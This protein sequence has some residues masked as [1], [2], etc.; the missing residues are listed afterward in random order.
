[1]A[2]LPEL[3]PDPAV[4][5]QHGGDVGEPAELAR[6]P[7]HPQDL[8]VAD[9]PEE[10][11]DHEEDR[12]AVHPGGD[13]D[14]AERGGPPPR[15][16]VRGGGGAVPVGLVRGLGEGAGEHEAGE[17]AE[18]AR[19]LRGVARLHVLGVAAEAVEVEQAAEAPRAVEERA[20]ADVGERRGQGERDLD[21]PVE[22]PRR[23]GAQE[24][25]GRGRGDGEEEENRPGAHG[26]H[27]RGGGVVH[28]EPG[29]AG[30]EAAELVV[31]ARRAPREPRRG[32]RWLPRRQ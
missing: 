6:E 13:L 31:R 5:L 7:D 15:G 24:A 12:D 18:G 1:M 27:A 28:A 2:D 3:L 22:G 4:V 23:S 19:E 8:Q 9:D 11:A 20:E 10:D 16:A 26:R 25:D 14:G 21:L 29:Q 30:A 32:G 17:D